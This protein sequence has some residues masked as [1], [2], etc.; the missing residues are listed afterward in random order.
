MRTPRNKAPRR[1]PS[2]AAAVLSLGALA[3]QATPT[4]LAIG[5]VLA[6]RGVHG[7]LKVLP[8]SPD[9]QRFRALHQVHLGDDR[10]PFEVTRARLHQGIAFLQL[11]GIETPEGVEPWRGAIVYVA[12]KDAVPLEA[13]EYFYYQIVGL[14][15]TTLEGESLGRVTEVLATGA[16]DVYVVRSD[17]G[18]ILLPAIKDVIVRVDLSAGMLWV[19]VPEGLR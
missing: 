9:P 13:D 17:A 3:P 5:K 12:V 2:E 10:V 6:P 1:R 15:V 4:H 7:E 18:E 19:R 16:N 14:A 8:E 11:R